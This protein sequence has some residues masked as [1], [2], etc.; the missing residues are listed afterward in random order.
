MVLQGKNK[1][2]EKYK[3]NVWKS[4]KKRNEMKKISRVYVFSTAK[5]NYF[6]VQIEDE[7]RKYFGGK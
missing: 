5:M 2:R 3:E 6:H 1:R 4:E 7:K